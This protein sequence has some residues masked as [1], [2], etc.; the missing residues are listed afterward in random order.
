VKSKLHAEIADDAIRQQEPSSLVSYR[1]QPLTDEV[2]RLY[3][4]Y[5]PPVPEFENFDQDL[6]EFIAAGRAP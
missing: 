4:H 3:D 1:R 2:A 5:W 6:A